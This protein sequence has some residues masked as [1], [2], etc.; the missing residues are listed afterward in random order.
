M[1]L[2]CAIQLSIRS[3]L[4]AGLAPYAVLRPRSGCLSD[5]LGAGKTR[6]ATFIFHKPP[7]RGQGAL[8]ALRIHCAVPRYQ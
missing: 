4:Q 6:H 7:H 1:L 8:D 5:R 3:E 2:R